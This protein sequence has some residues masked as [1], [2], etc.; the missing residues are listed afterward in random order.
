M[1]N[2]HE[3]A[4]EKQREANKLKLLGQISKDLHT[5]AIA[6]TAMARF[7]IMRMTGNLRP[8]LI[9]PIA[10]EIGLFFNKDETAE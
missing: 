2:A 1:G 7:E 3:E 5:I 4:K 10:E 8:E 6:Q 9:G